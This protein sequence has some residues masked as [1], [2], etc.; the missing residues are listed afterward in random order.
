[1]KIS[2]GLSIYNKQWLVEPSAALQ[3]LSFWERVK[4]GQMQWD[5][6]AAIEE[7]EQNQVK[8]FAG[9]GVK[10]AP[11]STWA[12]RDFKGFEGAKVAVIPVSGPLMKADY[13]GELGTAS[14]QALTQMAISAHSVK[15]IMF[16]VD[17]PGG[18]VDGT[19]SFSNTIKN[20]GKRTV[21]MISGIMASAAYWIGSSCNE[22]Y[23]S[24]S[25]SLV[26]SIGTMCSFYDDERYLENNGIVLRE[27]Y[28]DASEDKNKAMTEAKKGNGSKL[29]K[30][31]LN[32]LNDEFLA[33]VKENRAGKIQG[34]ETLTGKLYTAR[35]AVSNGLIDGIKSFDEVI[36]ISNSKNKSVMTAAE[37][38]AAHPVEYAQIVAEGVTQEKNRVRGWNAWREM[39]AEAVDKGIASGHEISQADISE[40]SAKAA[41][42]LR[43][44]QLEKDNPEPL[45]PAQ[46]VAP[47]TED[48]ASLEAN[49][50]DV[51]EGMGIKNVD[52]YLGK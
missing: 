26:G 41:N 23:A 25:T 27:F 3:M 21:C 22:V 17:S 14:L 19:Q 1:M 12:M 31:M 45:Q 38:K 51:L 39:D 28:A 7:S 44:S 18:T 48:Q 50:R 15:T 47:K 5:Y 32:P 2:T 52:K 49:T 13:C 24:E 46:V 37:Y 11:S 40:I 10:M 30:E 43:M 9:P 36:Q 42:K 35:Q 20:A 34:N 16:L 29:I 8:F 6:K 4:A 33:T